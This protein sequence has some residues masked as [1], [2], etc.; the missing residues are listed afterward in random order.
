MSNKNFG[1][2]MLENKFRKKNPKRKILVQSLPL[3]CHETPLV[4]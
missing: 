2:K 3:R 1:K 4:A